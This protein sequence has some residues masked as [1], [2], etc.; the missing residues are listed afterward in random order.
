MIQETEMPDRRCPECGVVK[1]VN[2][3]PLHA[4]SSGRYRRRCKACVSASEAAWIAAHKDKPRD[5]HNSRRRAKHLGAPRGI[6]IPDLIFARDEFVCYLCGGK[7]D[8]NAHYRSPEY[9]TIDHIIPLADEG[10]GYRGKRGLC[11]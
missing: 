7:T 8:P 6:Y 5:G 2:A 9:P 10:H 3:F 4:H 1:S 11:P